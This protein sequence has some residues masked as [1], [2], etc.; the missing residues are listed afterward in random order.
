[1]AVDGSGNVY[2]A[3]N[4][5]NLILK[6]TLSGG[7]YTQST[8][9]TSGLLG[10]LGVVVDGSGNVYIADTGH[11]RV[12]KED[13]GDPPSLSFNS[14]EFGSTSSD[15]P[16][17]VTLM[18]IG[19]AALRFPAPATGFNPSVTAGFTIGNSST[20]PQLTSGSSAATLP[21]DLRAPT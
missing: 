21:P 1:V 16:K 15:S 18:N 13:F 4:G 7:S 5:N 12:V 20:C 19:N 17:T 10:P 9:P 6:E 8:I 3:D 11:S 14:T 2:I